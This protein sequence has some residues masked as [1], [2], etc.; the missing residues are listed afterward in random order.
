MTT[1]PVRG[2]PT[3]GPRRNSEVLHAA[4]RVRD[5]TRFLAVALLVSLA[6]AGGLAALARRLDTLPPAEIHGKVRHAT[7][8]Q[9]R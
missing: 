7:L 9:P 3:D 4:S 5:G 8:L 6:T 1:W 2:G